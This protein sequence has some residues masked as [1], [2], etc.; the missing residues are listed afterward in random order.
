MKAMLV[1]DESL[2]LMQLSK[3]L[4]EIAGIEVVGEYLDPLL[5]IE[6]AGQLQPDVVFLDIH[7]PEILGLKAAEL[8]QEICPAAEIVFITA[9]DDYAVQAFEL[10]ALDY[11][12]KPLQRERL[13][14]TVQRLMMSAQAGRK[15]EE[16]GRPMLIRC[17]QTLQFEPPGVEPETLKWR[18]SKAQE[19]FSYL[20]HHR[21]QLVRKGVLLDLLWPDFDLAKAMTHLYTTIYQVRQDLKRAGAD[22]RI[23]SLGVQDGYILDTAQVR[24]DV[25]EWEKGIRQLA[26]VSKDNYR[27]HQRLLDMYRGDYFADSGYL[28][29]ENERQRLRMLWLQHAQLLGEFYIKEGMPAE[30][31]TVYHRVQQQ[32]PYF[33]ESY[34][35][36][37]KLYD[38]LEE[39]TAVEEQY[40]NLVQ[41]LEQELDAS[42]SN[43]IAEWYE[44]W[45]RLGP[46]SSGPV[47][48]TNRSV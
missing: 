7:M 34:F 28:W 5:A 48:K 14:K 27:A 40:K 39:R 11:V 33:E 26:A 47:R 2:A 15:E 43:R 32:Y 6:A 42:P 3:M 21:G 10:N 16:A 25:E 24:I 41:L 44:N 37:M 19:L 22:V 31:I 12:L 20:L 1:D 8:L 4:K 30:A 38:V 36:L 45:K 9:Y 18:T 35:A 23:R 17:L 13:A 46:G 29:A